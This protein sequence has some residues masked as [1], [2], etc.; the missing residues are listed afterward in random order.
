MALVKTS[1][2]VG[3]RGLKGAAELA[4]A[5]KAGATATRR[6]QDRSRLR[7]QKA[8]ERI[9][10]ATE[11]LAS[12]MAEASAA[13]EELS[14][15]LEQ[16]AA[17]AEEAAG[18]AHESHSA[19]SALEDEFAKARNEADASR[20]RIEALQAGISESA[21]LLE[22]SVRAIF[23]TGMRQTASV[24][25][26]AKLESQALSVG[27]TTLLV[28]DI[29]D[30]TNLVALNAAIEAARAG[31]T[32]RGFAVVAEEVRSLAEVAERSAREVKD[33][34]G[35]IGE[36]VRALGVRVRATAQAGQVQ[37]TTARS[38]TD[39]L[40]DI[41]ADLGL[42][43]NAS[44][45][46]L[47]AGI[48]ADLASREAGKAAQ[49]VASAAEEQ[50]SAAAEAQRAV[51]QQSQSLDQSQQ[52]AQSLAELAD[53]LQT[54]LA[55]SSR[56][57]QIASAAEQLSSTVQELSGAAGEILVALEQISRGA[58]AQA[59]AAQQT[60]AAMLQLERGAGD[61]ARSAQESTERTPRIG[62]ILR[63][64]QTAL[65]SITEG[66]VGSIADAKTSIET[67]G[68]LADSARTV[69]RSVDRI[70]AVA[71]QTTMLSVSGSIEA[72]RAGD[73]GHGFALVSSDIR[74]LARDASENIEGTREVVRLIQEQISSVRQDLHSTLAASEAELAKGRMLADRLEAI[75]AEIA[76]IG[77]GSGE[78]LASAQT[79][80]RA[81]RDVQQ[82][83]QQIAAA[84][85][86]AS[87]AAGEA[88]SAARQQSRGAE[89]LAA[90][91]E[92]IASLADEVQGL[93]G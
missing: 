76:V 25:I 33:I 4:P 65:R 58:Q 47:T 32:G 11:E 38:I 53:E 55:D 21:A 45:L 42:L 68:G 14:R 36:E 93:E 73:A 9:G 57:E 51:Q 72:A 52:A 1:S 67:L 86:E 44:Q 3:E 18:A 87:S 69:E 23:D 28:A 17:G 46:I 26:I 8:A 24:D 66:F 85:Q 84:A 16:I 63:K 91:I 60:E 56:G 39:S 90:A 83:T 29:S 6:T 50:S 15:S 70:A 71:M 13:A 48:Q 62:A 22:E 7:R 61:T 74:A 49:I 30:R 10:S 31:E 79:A 27:E 64:N 80:L 75:E 78:I 41:R 35:R 34:S 54:G 89:D 81:V 43:S 88:A 92:E 77:S 19:V 5:L 12:G 59:A 82:G 2:I 20:R 40:A 37:T